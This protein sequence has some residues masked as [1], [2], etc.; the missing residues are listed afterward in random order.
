[1]TSIEAGLTSRD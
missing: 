1:V